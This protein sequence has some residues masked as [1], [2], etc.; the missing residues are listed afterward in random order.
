MLTLTHPPAPGY[1]I[2]GAAL[3][4]ALTQASPRS[5][6]ILDE[7]GRGTATFDGLAIAWASAETLHDVIGCRALFATHYHE[8]AALEKR[9]KAVSNLSLQAR[10]HNGELIFL[11]EV[12]AG[13]ADRSYGVQV[14]KL[15]GMPP[16]VV[17]RARDILQRLEED[18]QTKLRL[19]DLPLFAFERTA[20][21]ATHTPS[22]FEVALKSVDPDE[23]SPK[24][25][26]ELIYNLHKLVKTV[27]DN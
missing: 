15:A 6:V 12:R 27:G 7:I 10:E 17:A 20:P 24:E 23:L 5:F 13:A 8:L 2:D 4:Q 22:K 14:A 16:A 25:A 9:M 21:V 11:H 19:D 18:N 26:L 3:R 1:R